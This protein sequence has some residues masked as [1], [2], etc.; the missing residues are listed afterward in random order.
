MNDR[1]IVGLVV[2]NHHGVL[3]RIAGLYGKRGYNIDSLAVGETEDPR[4]SRMTIVSTG[5][6]NIRTQ[7][8]KQ[9]NK[10]HD[11]VRA[12]LLD[13][14]DTI[15][16]EHLLIKLKT[17]ETG[18]AEVVSL[19]NRYGGK[20]LDLGEH[21]IIA[22]VTGSTQHIHAFITQCIPFGILELC[23]SGS[24]ALSGGTEKILS[25]HQ[26]NKFN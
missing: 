13:A 9:L 3:N 12:E 20:I 17:Q 7:V 18:N 25:A 6:R 16:V 10:L 4:F 1:F 19:I 22:D 21:F 24:L 8:V 2:A 15:S 14:P 23:R 26:K 11:V 5:N